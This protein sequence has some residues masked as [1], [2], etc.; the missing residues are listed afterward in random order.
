MLLLNPHHLVQDAQENNV[1][2]SGA[3]FD[4]RDVLQTLLDGTP[5]QPLHY[6]IFSDSD[7]SWRAVSTGRS[8]FGGG[9]HN[10]SQPLIQ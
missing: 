4:L 8:T 1:Q 2:A 9:A 3:V 10:S 6:R 7:M 5:P